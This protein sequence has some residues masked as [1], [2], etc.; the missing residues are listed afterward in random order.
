MNFKREKAH[1]V[2]PEMLPLFEK[3]YT[4]IAHFKDIPLDPD[5]DLYRK[6]EDLNILRIYTA[7]NDEGGLVGYAVYFLKHNPHYRSSFQ[8]CQDI[9]F[10]DPAARG[11]GAKFILWCDKELKQEGVQLVTQHIKV[12]TPHTIE[13]FKRL[14]YEP[15][16]VILAKRL[17]GA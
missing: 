13:L 6:M 15:I 4:E 17:D 8:A 5:L 12:A 3:H 7:R 1:D 10:V 2:I 14:G 9:L 16:D 11:V